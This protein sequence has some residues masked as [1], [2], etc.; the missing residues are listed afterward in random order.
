[1]STGRP[2]RRRASAQEAADATPRLCVGTLAQ[3]NNARAASRSARPVEGACPEGTR[4]G[5]LMLGRDVRQ[6]SALSELPELVVA[7]LVAKQ[8]SEILDAAEV[9]V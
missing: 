1:V 9:R 5:L 2:V 8:S 4:T 6:S 3:R 7:L